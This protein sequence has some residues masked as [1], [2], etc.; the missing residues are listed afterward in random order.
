MYASRADLLAIL[1]VDSQAKLS[2]DPLRRWVV[3]VGDGLT[4][5]FVTPFVETTTIKG[6]VDGTEQL[7]TV[8]GDIT[9]PAVTL[10]RGTDRDSIV[11]T[12]APGSGT[13][14][15]VTADAAAINADVIDQALTH[16]SDAI[17]GYFP[18]GVPTNLLTRVRRIAAVRAA[19]MLRGGRN[20][21]LSDPLAMEW[22]ADTAFLEKVAEGKIPVS[23]STGGGAFVGGSDTAVFV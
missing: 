13:T 14:V 5:T 4:R 22:K 3:G 12:T 21:D 11:F 15:G 10:S 17:G 19:V 9:T 2:T 23:S 20:L 8:E 18:A 6:Y 1:R 7:P 16:A